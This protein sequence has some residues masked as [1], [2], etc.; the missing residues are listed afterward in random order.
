MLV[1]LKLSEPLSPVNTFNS[2]AD[3]RTTLC[4]IKSLNY[5]YVYYDGVVWLHRLD[6]CYQMKVTCSSVSVSVD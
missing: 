1:Q 5:Y 2:S 6:K 4:D 3:C